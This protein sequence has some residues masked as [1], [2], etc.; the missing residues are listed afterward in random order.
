MLAAA[1]CHANLT[2]AEELGSTWGVPLALERVAD[3]AATGGQMESAAR[4]LGAAATL[5]QSQGVISVSV[6]QKA[7]TRSIRNKLV[8]G[9]GA[10]SFEALRHLGQGLT[11]SEAI[12]EALCTLGNVSGSA[13]DHR[14]LALDL[15]PSA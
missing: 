9:L 6:Q 4:L 8:A 2:L 13:L 12:G 5:R 14:V 3:L 7:H 10:E 11:V 1:N 15:P